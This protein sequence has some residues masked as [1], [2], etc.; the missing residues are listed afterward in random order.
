MSHQF[1]KTVMG[2]NEQ[3]LYSHYGGYDEEMAR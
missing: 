3:F 2:W 1:I